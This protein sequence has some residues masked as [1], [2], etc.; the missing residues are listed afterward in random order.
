MA[1]QADVD[2]G[3]RN[4]RAP[5]RQRARTAG[6]L[7]R[8]SAQL[9][10]DRPAGDRRKGQRQPDFVARRCRLLSRGGA[11]GYTK[12]LRRRRTHRRGRRR[13]RA[14]DAGARFLSLQA[15]HIGTDE[16][17]A[18]LARIANI[19]QRILA[20]GAYQG[21][22]WTQG[23][24]RVEETI[25]WLNLLLDTTV[26]VCG[27]AAQR[28][29]GQVSDDGPKNMVDSVDYSVARMGRRA[30]PQPGGMVL[31]QEQQIFAAR[32]VQKADAGRR[33]CGDRRPRRDHRRGGP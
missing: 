17:R 19:V 23:S 28:P 24:P 6:V 1:R 21:A 11:G 32:D 27:N 4:A 9:R 13:H 30:R 8:R 12:G 18:A 33:I 3:K 26:P 22:I 25:Y 14:G 31:I 15:C 10:G 2:R 16:P 20:S 29:H 5:G 7:S